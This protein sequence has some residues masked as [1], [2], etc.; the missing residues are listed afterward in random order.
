MYLS[1][2]A[3]NKDQ[4]LKMQMLLSSNDKDTTNTKKIWS[5][6]GFFGDQ[7]GKFTIYKAN[8]PENTPICCNQG[9]I[10]TLK[11]GDYT[12]YLNYVVLGQIVPAR[13]SPK[14]IENYV[15]QE[16]EVKLY[17]PVYNTETG[18][19]KGV[20]NWLAFIIVRGDKD[21]TFFFIWV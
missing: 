12:F 20:R 4:T 11:V 14:N 13:N 8:F 10:L 6:N 18:H 5:R 15:Y 17:M 3:T 2:E 16:N 7:K 19:F 1:K 21:E 9:S